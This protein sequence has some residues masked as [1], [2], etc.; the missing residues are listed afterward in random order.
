MHM[1][2]RSFV[3]VGLSG[4][5][6]TC[7]LLVT[8]AFAAHAVATAEQPSAS[9]GVAN[10]QPSASTRPNPTVPSPSIP[11]AS[12][13]NAATPSP[14][15]TAAAPLPNSHPILARIRRQRCD[16]SLRKRPDP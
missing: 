13:P 7:A 9:T 5:A 11:H 8:V 4:L 16:P 6:L 14:P 10:A 1:H 2:G 15:P 3:A 12:P